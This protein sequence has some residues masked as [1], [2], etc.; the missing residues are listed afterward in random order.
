VSGRGQGGDGDRGGGRGEEG[1]GGPVVK[2]RHPNH[3]AGLRERR[4]L[5]RCV[6]T[7]GGRQGGGSGRAL[8]C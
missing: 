2:G 6:E 5:G 7:V 8:H 1:G 3:H 4:S